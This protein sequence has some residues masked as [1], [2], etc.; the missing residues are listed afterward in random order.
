[1]NKFFIILIQIIFILLITLLVINNSFI[2]SIEIKD[3]IY[4]VSSSY[5]FIF[6]ILLFF[7]IFF[8]QSFYFKARFLLNSYKL[9][10]RLK[11]KEYGYD[12]FVS[13]MIA[14][15]NKDYKLAI[16]ESNKISKN[17]ER[18]SSLYLLLRSEVLK[19]EKKYDELS[20]TYEQMTKDKKTENLGYRGM[21]E[22]YLSNQDYHHAFI[23]GEKLFNNNPNIEKIYE[24]LVNI[25]VKTDNWHQLILIT[26][27][28][29]A[30]KLIDKKKY[31]E[32]KSIAF[33]EIA[34]I[35]KLDNTKESI[36]FIKKSIKLR[37]NFFPYIILYLDLLI[38][39]NQLVYAKK[40]IKKIWNILPH[41][42]YKDILIKLSNKLQINYLDLAKFITNNMPKDTESKILLIEASIANS[43]WDNAR[44][45]IKD[46]LN[47]QPD[48]Q[49]CLLMAKIEEGDNGDVQKMNSWILRS[50]NGKEKN[51]W[52]CMISGQHQ[53]YWSTLS[54]NGHFNSLEWRK[55]FM[56]NQ[57][58]D[59]NKKIIYEN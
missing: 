51:I 36:D 4:S 53:L 10:Q 9:K 3:Y 43:K 5:L 35:K 49:I 34:K 15:A 20:I 52:V 59:L 31:Q 39:D 55:P 11:N 50:Q 56:L 16:K 21:M 32:N 26:D 58:T 13:G 40:Y 46:L 7:I 37:G 25:V 57:L 24:T 17:R 23:Y 8:T 44:I 27:K 19:L 18:D 2:V 30:K 38:D 1:M 14:L 48:K 29:Y 6:F 54:K 12:S 45:I 33:Y 28:A 47:T 42:D 41:S 22:Q